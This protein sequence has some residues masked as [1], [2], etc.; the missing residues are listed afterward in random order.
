MSISNTLTASSITPNIRGFPPFGAIFPIQHV[1]VEEWFS[2]ALYSVNM[3]REP[4]A[5]E[6]WI[7]PKDP[8]EPLVESFQPCAEWVHPE[9]GPWTGFTRFIHGPIKF[10]P[11]C[12]GKTYSLCFFLIQLETNRLLDGYHL[13]VMVGSPAEE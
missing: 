7:T 3:Y 6:C 8:E 4:V 12:L 10:E 9:S 5:V 11:A 13:D 1:R 2:T